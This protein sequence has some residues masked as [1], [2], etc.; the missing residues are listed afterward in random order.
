MKQQQYNTKST[1]NDIYY[2][3]QTAYVQL[4]DARER[5]AASKVAVQQARESFE[6][7]QGRYKAGVCDAVEL[8]ESQVTYENAKLAYVSNV[9]TY[10]SAKASLEKAIGQSLKPVENH[11]NVEI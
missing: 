3:I 11:E 2:E 7:S 6:L 1:V 5:I 4:N 8:K 10:N 9:Y